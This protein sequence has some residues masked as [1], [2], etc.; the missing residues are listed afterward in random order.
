MR[1]IPCI[2]LIMFYVGQYVS[3]KI[4]KGKGRRAESPALAYVCAEKLHAFAGSMPMWH[5]LQEGLE[6]LKRPLSIR[7]GK[8]GHHPEPKALGG[9]A[10]TLPR[11]C[12]WL[13]TE[14]D[15]INHWQAVPC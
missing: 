9:A 11:A 1:D 4:K 13:Q 12:Q 8:T 6:I 2:G 15:S 14:A 10:R 5:N 7:Q 3:K